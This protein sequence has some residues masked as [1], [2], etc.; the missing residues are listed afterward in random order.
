M[1]ADPVGSGKTYVALA[2][3][4]T[5]NRGVTTCLV[6]ATLQKQWHSIAHS[7][8]VPVRLWSHEQASRGRLP[9][10]SRG[11]V[12]IDESHHFRHSATRRYRQVAPWLVGQTAL[13]I[14]ATPVVNRASDLSNQLL[15]TVPDDALLLHG[16]VSLRSLLRKDGTSASIG[17]VIIEGEPG[18]G[19]RPRILRT[20]SVPTT[21][22]CAKIG[23]IFEL[24][25][26]LQLSC[27][28]SIAALLRRVLLRSAGSS[29]AALLGTLGRY[30]RLLLHARDACRSGQILDRSE[31]R[32]FTAEL[33]DQ[34]IWWELFEPAGM[35][36]D[37][38]LNDL[39]KIDEVI[40][41]V[42]DAASGIDDKIQRLHEILSDGTPSLI[43]SSFRETVR[44]IRDAIPGKLAWCT[45]ER[46]GV[47]HTPVPRH[48]V[49]EWFQAGASSTLCPRHLVVT[50]VVAE[51]L[52]LQRAGRVI[53]YDLPWTPM[54]LD[55]RE[56]R[57]VRYGSS[58]SEVEV[59]RFT[60]P[61][62]MERWL[63]V[64]RVLQRKSRLPAT[65][66]LG[67]DGR[68]VWR[69]RSE[70]AARFAGNNAVA[71]AALVASEHEGLLAGFTLHSGGPSAWLSS[72]VL[73]LQRDGRWTEAPDLLEARL[74][75]AAVR[76]DVSPIDDARLRSWLVQLAV[77]IRERLAL[78]SSHRWLAPEPASASRRIAERLQVLTREAARMHRPDRLVQLEQALGFITRGHTAGETTLIERLAESSDAELHSTLSTLPRPPLP[79]HAIEV[80][81][82]GLI[83]FGAQS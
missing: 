72:T 6:P 21:P 59:V 80:R 46:A 69:W 38:D 18:R 27:S 33:G 55:Q 50:D 42:R 9:Q 3:A 37:I 1:L 41:S 67:P 64:E 43:F 25:A 22:E 75:E 63:G 53:H 45:G 39:N 26:P 81:L 62:I 73:W 47:G 23:R 79:R 30:R 82:T 51:G 2:A 4:A 15:L 56:G 76:I 70:L 29:T 5:L 12:L 7:L 17:H 40:G 35:V 58:Y 71:G 31:I 78:A 20:T 44:H 13:L 11:L 34:L 10:E 54:R 28:E 36:T 68:Q 61:P 19:T 49:L 52:N 14:T 24:L 8:G 57:S 48:S 77:A 74:L 16:I 32:R 60:P 83:L 65:L 66:G